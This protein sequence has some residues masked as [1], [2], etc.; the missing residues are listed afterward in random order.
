MSLVINPLRV[1]VSDYPGKIIKGT[2]SLTNE[3]RDAI[4]FSIGFTDLS[5]HNDNFPD[6]LQIDKSEFSLRPNEHGSLNYTVTIPE[7]ASGLLLAK[8]SFSK[9]KN[10]QP[11]MIQ[12]QTKL[13]I[14]VAVIVKGTEVYDA[15]IQT[16]SITPRDLTL[17]EVSVLNTGNVYVKP[18]G[19]CKIIDQISK[20][21]ISEIA[22]NAE[23]IAILPGKMTKITGRL[24]TALK[25]GKYD[26]VI[27]LPFP[28]DDHPI[29][30]LLELII[31]ETNDVND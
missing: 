15:E 27:R 23:A 6:W 28:D 5:L 14:Y 3:K 4:R 18:I 9:L 24:S 22:V 8:L 26:A 25:H 11:G 21:T 20:E 10:N 12:I 16:V 2:I 7:D 19:T 17:L 31:P 1:R 30:R 13:S 29:S